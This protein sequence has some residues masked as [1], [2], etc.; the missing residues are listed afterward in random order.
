MRVSTIKKTAVAGVLAATAA[1]LGGA[2]AHAVD[3]FVVT[4]TPTTGIPAAGGDVTVSFSGIPTDEG[5]YVVQCATTSASPRPTTSVNCANANME[6]LSTKAANIGAALDATVPQT[7]HVLPT[8]KVSATTFD[9]RT[10][11]CG[12]FV[13]RDHEGSG[14]TSL[15]TLVPLSLLAAAPSDTVRFASGSAGLSWQARE[16]LLARIVTYREADAVTITVVVPKKRGHSVYRAR[17]LASARAGAIRDFLV[18]N[19]VTAANITVT[20]GVV[21][22]GRVPRANLTATTYPTP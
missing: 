12:L 14:D 9:C 11:A 10:T 6:W 8:F 3:A 21:R 22:Q 18:A 4:V 19:G 13:R 7:F 17:H 16:A 20:Y 15:D 5:V 1:V 2:P